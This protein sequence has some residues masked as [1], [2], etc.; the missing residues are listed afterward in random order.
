LKGVQRGSNKRKKE[1][2]FAGAGRKEPPLGLFIPAFS[3]QVAPHFF[4]LRI[5]YVKMKEKKKKK[6]KKV[7]WGAFEGG[8]LFVGCV[9]F[10]KPATCQKWTLPGPKSGKKS[11]N[12]AKLAAAIHFRHSALFQP[13]RFPKK[14]RLWM[15]FFIYRMGKKNRAV[16]W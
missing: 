14:S 13:V 8:A 4:F 1:R 5:L 11:I 15:D 6:K 16:G 7:V 2:F 3:K 12:R 9:C 10:K